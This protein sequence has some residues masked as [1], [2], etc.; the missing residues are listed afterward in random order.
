[1]NNKNK[2]LVRLATILLL[3]GLFLAGITFYM[4]PQEMK[5]FNHVSTGTQY[6]QMTFLVTTLLTVLL[7]IIHA[8]KK[9]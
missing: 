5:A 4:V 9:N 8:T 2:G 3:Q 1:M 6:V 7:I